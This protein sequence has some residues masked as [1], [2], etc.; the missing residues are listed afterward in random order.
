[1]IIIAGHATR[2]GLEIHEFPTTT[3]IEVL[4]KQKKEF[5][6]LR[7]A[8][9]GKAFSQ[10]LRH[11]NGT[12][13]H[14]G[15]LPSI[16]FLSPLRYVS[17]VLLNIIYV[18]YVKTRHKK[19][20][21]FIGVDPLNAICGV[22]L[23]WLSVCKKT[24]YYS[25]DYSPRRFSNMMLNKLYLFCDNFSALHSTQVWNVSKRIFDIHSQL[26]VELNR[27][28]LLPNVPASQVD[29][30]RP[31]K[32]NHVLITLGILDDQ[33]DFASLFKSLSRLRSH[34]PDIK[35][36]IIGSGPSED[37]IKN[38]VSKMN[39]H[40]S[41]EF[42]GYLSHEKTLVEISKSGIGLALYNRRWNFNYYGD[43]MK[44]REFLSFG[45]P[46]ITTDT[47]STV[48]E[49]IKYNAGTIV[50]LNN[51]DSYTMSILHIIKNYD[52]FSNNARKLGNVYKNIHQK[53]LDKL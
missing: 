3:L 13:I 15:R 33:L 18:T 41:V 48:D 11:K 19:Q 24:I 16:P 9:D 39:L 43:S 28:L 31:R 34:I 35:L 51:V 25:V 45:L 7:H 12:V 2:P 47:H 26:G 23:C 36:K 30:R 5:I 27:N 21:I 49:I 40:S 46:I 6:Y 8:I 42:L 50:S 17:E 1:M 29:A 37:K 38:L 32:N 4:Q 44:C 53:Y 10:V 20:V 22:L 52:R 14:V